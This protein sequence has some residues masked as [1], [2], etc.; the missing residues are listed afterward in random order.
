MAKRLGQH[1]LFDEEILE[2]IIKSA[3]ITKKD[4]IIEI[5]PGKGILTRPLCERAGKVIAIE[6]DPYFSKTLRPAVGP[7]ANL[8]I[9]NDDALK[10][11]CNPDF[12][13]R[14][15]KEKSLKIV[16]NIPYQIT[17]PLLFNLIF[18]PLSWE[19]LVLLIQKE[20][21]NKLLARAN[22]S[23]RTF[24][25]VLANLWAEISLIS[26][27]PKTAFRPQPKV[28]GAVVRF[29]PKKP[30]SWLL[31]EK[32]FIRLLK[33]AFSAKRKTL[34]NV[35]SAGY[36]KEKERVKNLLKKSGLDP[37]TRAE[38]LEEKDWLNLYQNLRS[39]SFI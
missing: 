8:E 24:I 22:S 39:S 17:T 31:F 13:A 19:L 36:Q 9:I 15:K 6:L 37:N 21:A 27:V 35:L 23:D 29:L 28:D 4:T 26:F 33:I 11:L 30:V 2:K 10:I 25:T 20:V 32:E 12:L 1:F 38:D 34:T 7:F 16:S 3:Q 5:G 18:S 14:L